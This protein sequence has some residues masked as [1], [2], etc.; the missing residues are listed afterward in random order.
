MGSVISGQVPSWFQLPHHGR[1]LRSSGTVPEPW[2]IRSK[3]HLGTVI[4]VV[5]DA[6]IDSWLPD[7][8]ALPTAASAHESDKRREKLGKPRQVLLAD[9]QLEVV[10]L[11]ITGLSNKEIAAR[12]GISERA[13]KSHLQAIGRKANIRGRV[14]I[15]TWYL[16][17]Y[18]PKV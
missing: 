16:T 13:V 2:N 12:M 15:A 10:H 3:E 5:E 11:L 14:Q 9:K 4:L 17:Q 18:F 1:P 7:L 8:S 6:P